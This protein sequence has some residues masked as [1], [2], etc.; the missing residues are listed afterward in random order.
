MS[1]SNQ[2][3]I[4]KTYSGKLGNQVVF[5]NR[6]GKSIMCAM[7]K[8]I[9]KAPTEAQI[10]VRNLFL[11]GSIY[12]KAML[13]DPT[14]KTKYAEKA[15]NGKSAYNVALADY[16]KPPVVDNIDASAYTGATGDKIRIDATDCFEVTKVH[17]VI[18]DNSGTIVEQG[19]AALDSMNL[20]WEYSATVAHPVITGLTV[21]A[22]A[23]DNP[24][25]TGEK[26]LTL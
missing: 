18:K 12:A 23:T 13:A 17:V 5:R 24:G 6:D 19:D 2:N 26:T 1:K 21:T 11:K 15:I 7:P 9:T 8:P 16:I 22:T 4:T 10:N 3:V 25:H 20:F 14:M